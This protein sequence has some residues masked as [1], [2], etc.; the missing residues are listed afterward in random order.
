MHLAW[1]AGKVDRR[2]DGQEAL[3]WATPA[4]WSC[5]DWVG[6]IANVEARSDTAYENHDQDNHQD[7]AKPAADIRTTNVESSTAK[8]QNEDD[9]EHY[10][11]QSTSP[12]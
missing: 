8:K 4:A 10:Y 7:C 3:D 9:Q 1:P 12:E 11:V 6:I 5:N 2:T